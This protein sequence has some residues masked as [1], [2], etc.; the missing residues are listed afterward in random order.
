MNR[1]NFKRMRN[2]QKVLNEI[3]D[4][5]LEIENNYPELYQFLEENPIAIP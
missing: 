3:T 2:L 4:L 1:K 5:T